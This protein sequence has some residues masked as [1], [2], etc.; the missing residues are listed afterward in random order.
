MKNL[1]NHLRGVGGGGVRGGWV[2]GVRPPPHTPH[3]E[4]LSC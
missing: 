1:P 3:K 2:G 4:M